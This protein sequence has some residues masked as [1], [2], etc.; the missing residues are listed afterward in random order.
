M[1]SAALFYLVGALVTAVA[2]V[3]AVMVIGRIIYGIGIGLVR[4]Y[5]MLK[6]YFQYVCLCLK[7]YMKCIISCFLLS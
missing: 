7:R 3:L 2:P 4:Q 6:L 5:A 1:I